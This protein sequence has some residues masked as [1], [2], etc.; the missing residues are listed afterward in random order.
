MGNA[1]IKM[2]LTARDFGSPYVHPPNDVSYTP[3][4]SLR[5]QGAPHG[6]SKRQKESQIDLKVKGPGPISPRSLTLRNWSSP[7][8]PE[9]EIKLKPNSFTESGSHHTL[10]PLFPKDREGQWKCDPTVE[11]QSDITTQVFPDWTS[12]EVVIGVPEE[13]RCDNF[14]QPSDDF[15]LFHLSVESSGRASADSQGAESAPIHISKSQKRSD[16]AGF[17]SEQDLLDAFL[18]AWSD[19]APPLGT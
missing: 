6:S 4:A 10:L 2:C 7:F 17:E 14:H 13:E 12:D 5:R 1:T 8:S 18:V 9:G 15:S 3:L 11:M 16:D 19:S